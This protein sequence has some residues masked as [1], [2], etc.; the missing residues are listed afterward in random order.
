LTD[1][2]E[3]AELRLNVYSARPATITPPHAFI[4]RLRESMVHDA[5]FQERTPLVDVIV[6][7]GVFDSKDAAARRD[8]FVDGFIE[9]CAENPHMAG[10]NTVLGI[11]ATEDDPNWVAEWLAAPG[12][13]LEQWYATTFTIQGYG[14]A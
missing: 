10:P 4:D 9:W 7:H 13:A 2:K 6:V 8:A 5:G 11:V 14:G 1:Y 12:K 3:D